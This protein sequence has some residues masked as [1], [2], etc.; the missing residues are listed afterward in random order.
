MPSRRAPGT[1]GRRWLP[2]GAMDLNKYT[3]RFRKRQ[4]CWLPRGA[5]DLN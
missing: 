2:R 3:S 1:G 5:M 4:Y